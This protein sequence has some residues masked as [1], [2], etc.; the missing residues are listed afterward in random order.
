M[1][2]WN[3]RSE[4][5]KGT[6]TI[7]QI[8][9]KLRT[10]T[11]EFSGAPN[12]VCNLDTLCRCKVLNYSTRGLTKHTPTCLEHFLQ[13]KGILRITINTRSSRYWVVGERKGKGKREKTTSQE[14]VGVSFKPNRQSLNNTKGI[15]FVR[16]MRPNGDWTNSATIIII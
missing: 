6:Q 16:F 9:A 13:K 4:R 11:K 2:R 14:K 3:Q 12:R 8:W 1:T 7:Q 5:T 10:S 15:R